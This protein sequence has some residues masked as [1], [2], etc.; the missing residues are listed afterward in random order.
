MT[1]RIKNVRNLFYFPIDQRHCETLRCELHS[2]SFPSNKI[3]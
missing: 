1:V 2:N 3:Y